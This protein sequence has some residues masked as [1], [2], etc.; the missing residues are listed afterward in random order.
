MRTILCCL[1]LLLTASAYGA[2]Y[3]V[4]SVAQ[5]KAA[6][7][8]AQSDGETSVIKIRQGSYVLD[9]SLSYGLTV[10]RDDGRLTLRGGYVGGT[11]LIQQA[12]PVGTSIAGAQTL[13]L[14][15]SQNDGTTVEYLT[16]VG[17][18]V[19]LFGCPLTATNCSI[20]VNRV[21]GQTSRMTINSSSGDGML[22]DSLFTLGRASV[23]LDL[24]IN[25]APDGFP[26]GV[27][28]RFRLIN[29]SVVDALARFGGGDSND[30]ENRL[31]DIRNSSF[32]R[33][34][35]IE[36]ET[37]RDL[38][39]RFSRYD[40]L[41][42]N[43]G[44]V[45]L[46]SNNTALQ[47]NFN[48][49][50]I[51]NPGSPL[52]DRGTSSVEG[53]LT[54][55][56]YNEPR[57]IGQAVD[58]GAAESPVDGS[59][60]FVV[61][62]TASSGAGSLAAAVA[63]ANADD[64]A[65]V[66]RFNIPGSCPIRI[67]RTSALVI[68]DGLTFDGYSQP[69]SVPNSSASLF[70]GR[71]CIILDGAN[72]THDGI[73]A[74]AELN[75]K[76]EGVRIVGL[77]FEDFATAVDLDAGL[78]HV[79]QGNQFG[80]TI[81][82]TTSP[83]DVLSGNNRAISLNRAA[84]QFATVGGADPDDANLVVGAD[85]TGISIGSSN[86]TVSNNQIGYD[87]GIGTAAFNNSVGV[88]ITGTDNL[89]VG[90][91]FG[92]HTLDALRL[93]GADTRDNRVQGNDFGG[94][95]FSL[96]GPPVNERYGV[97]IYN[98]AHDN[99]IGP[100]NVFIGNRIGVRIASTA[101][102]RNR[103]D[104][105][106]MGSQTDLGIDLGDLGVTPNSSDP[107]ICSPTLGCA[108]NGEQNF[109]VLSEVQFVASTTLYVVGRLTSVVRGAPYELQFFAN[110]RCDE[111]GHGEGEILLETETVTITNSSC[112]IGNCTANFDYFIQANGAEPNDY[113]SATAT[114]PDGST[115]EF[116]PCIRILAVDIIF[117]DDFE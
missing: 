107:Q 115:S 5:L 102:G 29:V 106:G 21:R 31:V 47:P 50:F 95:S 82:N 68:T 101:G 88:F 71:P 53:G 64:F 63:F 78:S 4:G 3:C 15:V 112:P 44:A 73:S 14:Q 98:D 52:L 104:S 34:G 54:R 7:L 93:T 39:V 57:L 86:N 55:D 87:R 43:N 26:F 56:V 83:A 20:N 69:G 70:N 81:G 61:D 28:G 48:A 114:A 38:S 18:D 67:P 100:D 1:L 2:D 16:F 33:T 80:G 37:D 11:C 89:V 76:N 109:P 10:G 36:I 13:S 103:I 17:L 94:S 19:N 66:I 92:K 51:P 24:V 79:I 32:S 116:A 27:G 41:D 108:A 25:E 45:V 117:T 85:A 8:S 75:A 97:Y 74:G 72:R 77:A 23:A 59:G 30:P 9:E 42:A 111:S 65:N 105:N 96:T 35:G 110:S 46:V 22:R 62:T 99:Q 49:Q 90:N 91:R 113:L 6:L 12:T 60:A 84:A 40:T 58:I